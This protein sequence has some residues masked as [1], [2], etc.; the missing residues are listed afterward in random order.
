MRFA[1]RISQTL[2][3]EPWG[4]VVFMSERHWQIVDSAFW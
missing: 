1:L 3:G 4:A 2:C